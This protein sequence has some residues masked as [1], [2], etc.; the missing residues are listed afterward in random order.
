MEIRWMKAFI[1]VA[2]E[3][4][5]GR[6][7]QRL[8]IAQPAVSQQ[9]FHL[10]RHLGIQL[11]ERNKRT[12]RLTDAGDA[13]LEPC[14]AALR[15]IEAASGQARNAGTGEFGKIR[16]GFN[17]GFTADHL[18]ALVRAV[19]RQYPN[20]ELIIDSSRRN[21]EVIKKVEKQDLDIGL[22]GGPVRGEG[23]SWRTIWP[24]HL[25]VLM[26]QDHPLAH[27]AKVPTLALKNETLVLIFQA[28][29]WTIR[30]MAEE[31]CDR[32]G[33]S[34]A[35]IIEVADGM[36]LSALINAKVGLAFATTGAGHNTAKGLV[37]RPLAEE[38]IVQNSIVWK[39]GTETPALKN[40]LKLA[41][42]LTHTPPPVP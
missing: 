22:V 1:A 41:Q 24:G 30:S 12:V 26:P 8:H 3:L 21:P 17:A 23:L 7:A 19:D 31:A 4:N 29:G 36:T 35:K 32:A 37:M 38:Y 9:I 28:P 34:P 14:R 33:F 25:G 18:V 39:T 15:S 20:M 11:F 2:E 5:F 10:E 13:F 27:L 42:D 16:I 40:V 6:A